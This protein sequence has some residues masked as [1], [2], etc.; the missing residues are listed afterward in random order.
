MRTN[1]T[2]KSVSRITGRALLLAALLAMVFSVNAGSA[3][4]SAAPKSTQGAKPA[5][6]PA[7]QTQSPGA[8]LKPTATQAEP[9]ALHGEKPSAKGDREG[10]KV[11]GHWT[12][13]VKN[14][15]GKIASHLDFENALD[16]NEGADLLTG[17]LS[18]EY[19]PVG[20]TITLYNFNSSNGTS[21]G[22]CGNT[23]A[24]LINDVRD[25]LNVNLCQS[26]E[27]PG[28]TEGA[29]YPCGGLL[30][31]TPNNGSGNYKNAVGYTLSGSIPNLS[32]GG[33]ITEVFSGIHA[34]VPAGAQLPT[35]TIANFAGAIANAAVSTALDPTIT[36][37]NSCVLSILNPGSNTNTDTQ[38]FFNLTGTGITLPA[39]TAGQSISVTV[40]ITFS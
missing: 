38:G 23:G 30:T 16:G 13:D 12:I 3:Q 6:A 31:Y 5:L 20:F 34:C 9:Q 15:D 37:G 4:S 24:C 7:A 14:P 2:Q 26:V 40:V 29:G 32:N 19:I 17:M 22:L 18:G 21:T 35:L 11:H 1:D 10:I 33:T 27:S 39:V 28:T 25:P 36:Q 8:T